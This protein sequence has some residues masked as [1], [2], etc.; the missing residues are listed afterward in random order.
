MKTKINALF[1]ILL[2][3]VLFSSCRTYLTPAVLGNNMGYIPRAMGADSLKTL[4]SVS[5]SYAGASAPDSKVSFELAMANVNLSHT[6]EKGNIAFGIFG[7][8]GKAS[9]N[10]Q[11]NAV[12]NSG[13]YLPAF[14][15]SITGV[16]LRFS[17]GLHHTSAN[18]NTD[19]RFINFENAISFEGGDYTAFRKEIYNNRIPNYVAVTDR[20][21]LWTTGLSTEVIWRAR[22]D[23]GIKHGFRLFLGGTPGLA[24][25]FKYGLNADDYARKGNSFGFIFNYSLSVNRF[26]LA[27]E[28]GSNLNS[29]QKISLGYS[30]Q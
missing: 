18:G 15:K 1:L 27:Y 22:N 3:A 17:A 9:N 30:F 4:T 29:A 24:D 5:A 11:N 28:V 12:D 23:H 8:T 21:V 7:Y 2:S 26:F 19:F 10:V 6:F 20:K 14:K 25:S 13:D 16:G